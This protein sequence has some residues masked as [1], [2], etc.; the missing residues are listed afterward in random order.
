MKKLFKLSLIALLCSLAINA[1]AQL[2]DMTYS[3]RTGSVTSWENYAFG[4]CWES[5]TENYTA[6]LDSWDNVNGAWVGTGCQTC[7]N[8][9]NCTYATNIALQTR[10]NNAYTISFRIDAWEDD[11]CRCSYEGGGCYWYSSGD[12]CRRNE[13]NSWNIREGAYPSN[14]GYT[15]TPTW[16]GTNDHT[17][18]FQYTWKYS[19]TA[20]ALYPDCRTQSTGYSAGAIRSWSV[21]MVAGRTYRF[22]TC[23]TAEDTYLRIFSGDGYSNTAN[24]DDNGPLCGG[25]AA[26]GDYTAPGTGWYYLE[27]SHYSRS[28]LTTGGTL[29]YEDITTP[30]APPATFGNGVWYTTAYT[31]GNIDLTGE[32]SGYYSES[33]LTYNS[34]NRWGTNGSPSDA[35]GW[36]G[37]YVPV[38]NHVVVSRRT[39]FTCGVYQLDMPNH[40]DDVRVYVNGSQVFTHIGCC[41]A[42]TNLWT[43]YLT[44]TST[45]EVRHLE[46]GGGS[47][48]SLSVTAVT[49]AL[50][51]GTIAGI[52]NGV[53]ICFNTDPGAFTNTASPSGGTIGVAN[54]SP[55]APVYEWQRAT[56]NTFTAGLTVVGGNSL[57]YD[58]V[59][60]ASLI[61]GTY[62]FRR[63]V[64]DAC[65]TVAYSNTISVIVRPQFTSGTILNTGQTIC[66]GG[67]PSVIGNSVVASGGDNVITYKWQANGVDIGCSNS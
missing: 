3:V 47:H 51:G 2:A 15:A 33:N 20:N 36:Q 52:T 53:T 7:D 16:G 34:L 4:A 13:A 18:Y 23:G 39:G 62:Y 48:Q 10:S 58:P 54:G 40:D 59:A 49:P 42:H 41:D 29:T 14:G 60:D 19:G 6:Y 25:T 56:N 50:S 27:L 63:K 55:A 66:Y 21:Y 11:D 31:G 17:Y 35:S 8:N 64:T 57:T 5:A 22:G 45:I 46:G 26:S 24:Y 61:G 9:G 37:C 67:D 12:D 44:S 28:T 38:D 43:G 65:G 1:K 32:Y 30:P